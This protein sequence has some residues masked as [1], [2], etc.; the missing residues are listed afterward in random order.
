MLRLLTAIAILTPMGALEAKTTRLQGIME[1]AHGDEWQGMLAMHLFN[2]HT[3]DYAKLF[4]ACPG[5]PGLS[6]PCDALVKLDAQGTIVQVY[7][8]KGQT[9]KAP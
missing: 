4:E 3:K 7:S 2:R 1:W 6:I 5:G 8:A 9:T